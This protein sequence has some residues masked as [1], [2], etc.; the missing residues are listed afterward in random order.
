MKDKII[1]FLGSFLLAVAVLAAA[2]LPA[3]LGA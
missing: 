1:G 3:Q 2:L